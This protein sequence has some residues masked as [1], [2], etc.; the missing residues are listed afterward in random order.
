[1]NKN[2]CNIVL[3]NSN[4][5]LNKQGTQS[6]P[7]AIYNDD[8][9]AEAVP[10][11]WHEEIELIVVLEGEMEIVIELE[12]F[13]LKP[14][15]GIFIN[16]GRLHSCVNYKNSNCIIKSFVFHSRFLYG[17]Q[18][19]VMY[20]KY[21]HAFLQ[22]TAVNYHF[23]NIKECEIVLNAY[24]VF[25]KENYAF[26]FKLRSILSDVLVAIIDECAELISSAD[27][28]ILKQLNRCKKMMA[29]IH[30]NY[31]SELSLIDIAKSANIKESEALRC[32]KTV[33]STSPI[34]YLKNF[35]I[36]QAA[37]QLKTSTSPIIE[38]AL[39]CGFT[40][41]SYFS[42]SFKEVYAV[43]PTEYR[44]QHFI[45]GHMMTA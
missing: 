31:N 29:Y 3:D 4:R 37:I 36:E 18:S 20:Q 38:I 26:E 39:D 45:K 42:K 14:K 28:K 10:Y 41:I 44:K 21:F 22:E 13:I 5:E 23:L 30:S 11:H 27:N 25:S 16:S 6:F 12:K 34:K 35:R 40:E 1:M 17:E 9:K 24:D 8:L 43:T 32:F 15:E 33:L 7:V 2:S 19:S